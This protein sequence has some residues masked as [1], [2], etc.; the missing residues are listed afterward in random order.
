MKKTIFFLLACLFAVAG[1]A[2]RFSYTYK[3]VTFRCKVEKKSYVCITQ[4]DVD[5][6]KVVIPANVSHEG[7]SYPVKRID[8]FINGHNYLATSLLVEEGVEQIDAYS[9]NEFRKLKEV[10]LPSSIKRVGKNA[11]REN[12]GMTFNLASA[13]LSEADLR[14]GK[15]I[16]PG[17]SS[18]SD[19]TLLAKRE[20]ESKKEQKEVTVNIN[21]LSLSP[22]KPS[23]PSVD[24]KRQEKERK[25]RE[26]AEEEARKQAEQQA[27]EAEQL[28]LAQL[29]AAEEER[30]R[31]EKEE[32]RLAEEERKR[33]LALAEE[34]RKE[35][36][37]LAKVKREQEAL[38]LAE[39]RRRQEELARLNINVDKNI[40]ENTRYNG[41][42][43][44]VI[45]A[46]ENYT[47][48]PKVDYALN[49]G[50]VFKE[51]CVKTLGIPEKRIR[52]FLDASYTDMKRA[53]AF[54]ENAA[55]VT[56]GKGRLIFYYAGHGMPNDQDKAAYLIPTDA[57]PKEIS[58]CFKMSDLYR[59]LGRLNVA[60]CTVLLDACFSGVQRG[61]EEMLIAGRGVAYAPDEEELTGNVVVLSAASKEETAHAY[62]KHQHGMFTYF[63]LNKLSQTKGDVTL[64]EL[65]KFVNA[66]VMQTSFDE[67]QKLQTPSVNASDAMTE[68]WKEIYF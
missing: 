21:A 28:R 67:N 51:Y 37:R 59:Q 14:D 55:K 63:L 17:K 43:Y 16:E 8:T 34:Q 39:E 3:G 61:K 65:F 10:I 19:N 40:P 4:F 18:R 54:M 66:N 26:K 32:A 23:V 13:A 29:K 36:E 11:F 64:E 25:A 45:I 6:D 57:Y 12:K 2:Q 52:T 15:S 68:R 20:V 42:T 22:K 27:K 47:D 48:V 53:I 30:I 50:R 35:Q 5:A 38:R 62:E 58:T 44:C 1:M 24:L 33:Q 7:K 56:Q 31:K 60:S 9:F 46:N 41:D 49:D